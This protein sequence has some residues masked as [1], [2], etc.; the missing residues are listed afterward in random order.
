MKWMRK[1]SSSF[2]MRKTTHSLINLRKWI[3]TK[4]YQQFHCNNSNNKI[5]VNVSCISCNKYCNLCDIY[6]YR[7][8]FR[9]HGF[10][11]LDLLALSASSNLKESV[12]CLHF[13]FSYPNSIWIHTYKLLYIFSHCSPIESFCNTCLCTFLSHVPTCF[14]ISMDVT[15]YMINL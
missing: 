1:T 10:D 8:Q 3:V 9:N 2:S 6:I 15:Q 5:S 14:S 11:F 4:F 13:V 7:L 12:E